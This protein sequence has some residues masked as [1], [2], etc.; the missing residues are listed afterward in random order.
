MPVGKAID[1]LWGKG[2]LKESERAILRFV[3]ARTLCYKKLEELIPLRHFEQGVFT[4]DGD[5]VIS[6]VACSKRTIIRGIAALEDKGLIIVRR[7]R[8]RERGHEANAFS[9]CVERVESGQPLVTND[10]KPSDNGTQGLRQI[11]PTNKQKVNIRKRSSRGKTPGVPPELGDSALDGKSARPRKMVRTRRTTGANASYPVVRPAWEAA[12]LASFPGIPVTTDTA[13]MAIF[14]QIAKRELREVD[15]GHFFR[16]AVDGW[17]AMRT[18]RL[19]W[20]NKKRPLPPTPSF[21]ALTKNLIAFATAYAEEGIL[22]QRSTVT[23]REQALMAR[24]QQ[25]QRRAFATQRELES[26]KRQLRHSTPRGPALPR[27]A[28]ASDSLDEGLKKAARVYNEDS[29]LGGRRGR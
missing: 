11:A 7:F 27:P 3:N 29:E 18:G 9:I 21:S 16:W 19:A 22:Y 4:K 12:L 25:E 8:S 10:T 2:R 13:S 14:C 24:A 20:V 17:D 1:S 5:L 15:L 26:T 23:V 28:I 6:G